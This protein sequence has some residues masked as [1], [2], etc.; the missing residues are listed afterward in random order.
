MSSSSSTITTMAGREQLQIDAS[1]A[2]RNQIKALAAMQGVS[3][4]EF[5]LSAVAEKHPQLKEQ[6]K[7]ELAPATLVDA[8]NDLYNEQAKR[9]K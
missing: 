3:M 1:R 6:I 7:K 8:L 9:S 4:R 5:V 2:L